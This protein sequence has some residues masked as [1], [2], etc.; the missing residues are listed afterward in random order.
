VTLEDIAIE[1]NLKEANCPAVT[2]IEPDQAGQT[3]SFLTGIGFVVNG[4]EAHEGERQTWIHEMSCLSFE[5]K[6]YL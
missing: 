4:S 6:K 1:P 3:S 2:G 5:S